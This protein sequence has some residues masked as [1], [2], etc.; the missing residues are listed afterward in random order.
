MRVPADEILHIFTPQFPGQLRGYPRMAGAIVPM[1]KLDEY[2]D[3]L[4]ERAATASKFA[5]FIKKTPPAG[6]DYEAKSPGDMSDPGARQFNLETGVI[7]ELGDYESWEQTTPPDPG[8]NYD[9]FLRRQVAKGCAAAGVPY[10]EVSGDLK[11]ANFSSTRVG[12]QP[13]KRR[14]ERWGNSV[15]VF[16][17]CRPVWAMWLRLGLLAQ[18][19]QLPRGASR[20][21][22]NYSNLNWLGPKWEYVN[23]Y[24]DAQ[25]DALLVDHGFKPRSRVIEESGHNADET[26]TIIKAD[27][28]R[29]DALGLRLATTI[30][31][32]P[33]KSVTPGPTDPADPN[34]SPDDGSD[35]EDPPAEPPELPPAPKSPAQPKPPEPPKTPEPRERRP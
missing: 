12:R 22:D 31:S 23:P 14:C 13:F 15:L 7:Y 9:D 27:Q 1:F 32:G 5:G 3:A 11:S 26:D 29:Q 30:P 21:V 8:S 19:V 34:A 33:A 17:L 28:D 4:L 16:Q 2:E 25:A 18:K 20:N 6:D 35:P 24:Q 10:A